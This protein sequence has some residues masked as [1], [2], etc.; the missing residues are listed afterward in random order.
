M[1]SEAPSQENG[2][3]SEDGLTYTFRLRE[4]AVWED[5]QAIRAQDFVYG[6]QRLLDPRVGSHYG[7]TYYTE[8][9]EGGAD[10]AFAVDAD[11][12]TIQ[13][14]RDAASG[15]VGGDGGGAMAPA[16][17]CPCWWCTRPWPSPSP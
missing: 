12:A 11:E 14:L 8:I 17:R 10:L 15:L 6:I 13:Q 1:A 2:G 3:I 4:D 5:G 16:T 9:V 7:T